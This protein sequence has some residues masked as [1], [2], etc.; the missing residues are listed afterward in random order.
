[1]GQPSPRRPAQREPVTC[2]SG[3]LTGSAGGGEELAGAGAGWTG[4]CAHTVGAAVEPHPAS[5]QDKTALGL[6]ATGC[7]WSCRADC[8]S[9]KVTEASGSL[10]CC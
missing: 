7:R 4:G 9:G 1:M 8:P 10:E 6:G 5:T 2:G 3:E